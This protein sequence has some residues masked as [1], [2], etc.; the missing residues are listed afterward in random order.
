MDRKAMVQMKS[1]TSNDHYHCILE[2]DNLACAL[3]AFMYGCLCALMFL[4]IC[5]CLIK[6][7]MC[8]LM[9]IF[10]SRQCNYV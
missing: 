7:Q 6:L 3:E 2:Q 4:A 8:K 9:N 5:H 10:L 1:G